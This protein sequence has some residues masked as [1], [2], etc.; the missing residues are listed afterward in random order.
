MDS[1]T[2]I[3]YFSRNIGKDQSVY[4]NGVKIAQGLTKDSVVRLSQS[5]IRPGKNSFVIL[6]TPFLKAQP[7]E[8]IS[9]DPGV[10]Q[11]LT[12]AGKWKRKLFNGYAQVLV[13]STGHKGAITLRAVAPGIPAV[14]L[15]I[16][17]K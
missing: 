10:I 1:K 2:I 5:V 12:P 13:Q 17:A 7:W 3:N 6:A 14:Q 8:E 16:Q 9:K 4:I 15:E 11:L